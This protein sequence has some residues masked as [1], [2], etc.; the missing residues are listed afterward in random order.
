MKISDGHRDNYAWQPPKKNRPRKPEATFLVLSN[1]LARATQGYFFFLAGA[2]FAAF[3]AAFL[4]A[5][6][7]VAILPNVNL[8]SYTDRSVIHI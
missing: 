2:F 8:Q 5:F 3:F 6:F 1:S 4:V 7:I